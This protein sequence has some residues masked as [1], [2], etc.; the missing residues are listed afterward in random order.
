MKMFFFIAALVIALSVQTE[1]LLG[2][3]PNLYVLYL[4]QLAG[5][6]G[7]YHDRAYGFWLRKPRVMVAALLLLISAISAL[8]AWYAALALAVPSLISAAYLAP[9]IP[10][11][12]RKV[13]LRQ[14]PY[15]KVIAI[16]IVWGMVTVLVPSVRHGH[17]VNAGLVLF[18]AERMAF[19]FVLAL[20]ADI[21]DVESDRVEGLKTI[22]LRIGKNQSLKLCQFVLLVFFLLAIVHYGKTMPRMLLLMGITAAGVGLLTGRRLFAARSRLCCWLADVLLLLQALITLFLCVPC[23]KILINC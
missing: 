2:Y 3:C 1:V 4:V 23:R 14:L 16:T 10:F 17:T 15:A 9:V 6:G 19:V 7:V 12:G 5:T 18:L 8:W 22:P 13:T 11:H 20:M 21:R